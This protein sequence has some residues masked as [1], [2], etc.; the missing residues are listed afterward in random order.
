MNKPKMIFFD[1]GQT[2]VGESPYNQEKGF[3]EVL[4]YAKANPDNV[5]AK[6]TAD[7]YKKTRERIWL[8][9]SANIEAHSHF[10]MRYVME[11]YNIE[12]DFDYDRV[13]QIFWE[14]AVDFIA[15][16]GI[17]KVLD[18][19]YKNN[20][21]TAVISNIDYSEKTLKRIIDRFIPNHHFEYIIASSEY[22]FRK[23]DHEIFDIALRK[24]GI[25]ACDAWYIGNDEYYDVEGAC[26]N[27]FKA[28]WYT[29]SEFYKPKRVPECE[30]I[31]IEKWSDFA[32][33]LA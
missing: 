1:Y 29:G 33:F 27:G 32:S 5:S 6:E 26:K 25:S 7:L 10:L 14:N 31:R 3:A 24:A 22:I 21:R 20:I 4:K 2:L 19:L 9:N 8:S 30:H 16:D 13:E 17:D 15:L 28:F 11:Y 23:P 12:F 18:T